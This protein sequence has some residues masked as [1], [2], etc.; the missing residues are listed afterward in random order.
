MNPG[1]IQFVR[2]TKVPIREV[3]GLLNDRRH[4]PLARDFSVKAVADWGA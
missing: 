4:M 3:L 2:L 1:V